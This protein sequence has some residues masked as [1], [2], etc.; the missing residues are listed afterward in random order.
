MV[1]GPFRFLYNSVRKEL[2]NEGRERPEARCEMRLGYQQD[3][4]DPSIGLWGYV[5]L[6]DLGNS[7]KTN[8]PIFSLH[9]PTLL[10]RNGLVSHYNI[11]YFTM[12]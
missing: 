2:H 8:K 4:Y 5:F 11:Y 12:E 6:E 3:D 1:F 7:F 9:W 10:E